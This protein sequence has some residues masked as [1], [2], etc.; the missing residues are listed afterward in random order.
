MTSEAYAQSQVRFEAAALGVHLFR[1]QVGAL[2]DERG[3]LVRFGLANDS[4]ALNAVLKSSDLIGFR[5]HLVTLADVGRTLAVFTCREIK[6]PG[7][8]KPGNDRELAQQRWI[9]LINTH[10]GDGAFATGPGSFA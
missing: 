1:N 7:W 6:A 10:G 8:T 2:K 3:R 4:A 9:D 5:P